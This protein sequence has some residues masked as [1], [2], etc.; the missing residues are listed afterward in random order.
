MGRFAFG[1]AQACGREV[2]PSERFFLKGLKALS[3]KI[4]SRLGKNN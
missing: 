3:F 1:C 4:K 2:A